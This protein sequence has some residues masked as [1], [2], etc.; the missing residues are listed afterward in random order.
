MYVYAHVYVYVYVHVHVY[1]YVRV[2]MCACA[3]VTC[4]KD[5]VLLVSQVNNFLVERC[6]NGPEREKFIVSA[7][8]VGT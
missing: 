6:A 4:R 2:C 1:V 7:V 3:C 8:V 5:T